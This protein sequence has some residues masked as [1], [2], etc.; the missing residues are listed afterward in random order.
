MKVI[1]KKKVII[2]V[3]TLITLLIAI[4]IGSYFYIRNTIY[5]EEKPIVEIKP[6]VKEEVQYHE[7]K[8]ITN[9]L[10]I[11][12]DGR[13]LEESSR[14]DS[15]IIATIDS[16]NQKIKFTSIMR[17]TY[18][19]IPEHGEQ[20]INAAHAFGGPELLMQTIKENFGLSLDKYIV[21][22]FW[23]FE[24]IVDAMGGLD[25]E[26][27]DYEINEINKYIGEVRDDKSPPLEHEGLQNLDGQQALAYARIRKV[28]NGSYERTE[29]Q[30]YVMTLLSQKGKEISPLK[31]PSVAN[32]LLGC[33]KTNIEP[34]NLFNYAYT[35]YKF[36]NPYY[37]QLQ[38]PANELSEGRE[39]MDK[40]WVLLID[41]E[42]NGNIMKDFILNDK[43][44]DSSNY[45]KLAFQNAMSQYKYQQDQYDKS[46]SVKEQNDNEE[47]I[48]NV[49][50]PI[51]NFDNTI[52]N[53]NKDENGK[54]NDSEEN[55]SNSGDSK[56][57][58]T[59]ETINKD[60]ESKGI[61]TF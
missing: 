45:N 26:V 39:F 6:E 53:G 4:S 36:N 12:T 20:K 2:I 11:G 61:A 1:N 47:G 52:T 17:D 51:E 13:T 30:R 49:V 8:G 55:N 5:V 38:I 22:N 24:D 56:E 54:K 23:G 59:K 29:R 7:E 15:I 48:K 19:K 43:K 37:D 58:T 27:K 32:A 44:W 25:I 21:V 60:G 33:V 46:K 3:C 9:I 14:S 57:T 50:I 34:V 18:V 28:G 42:Q 16:I 40:G 41:R 31:Y 10:L 35:F